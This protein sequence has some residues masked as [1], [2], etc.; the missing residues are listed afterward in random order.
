[1]IIIHL[2]TTAQCLAFS[3]NPCQLASDH[4]YVTILQIK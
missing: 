3:S 1:M 4:D 2:T